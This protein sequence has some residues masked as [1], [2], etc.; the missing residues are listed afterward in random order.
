MYKVVA[1]K[2]YSVCKAT[3]WSSL[4]AAHLAELLLFCRWLKLQIPLFKV[5]GGG[6]SSCF[7]LL[8]GKG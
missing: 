7:P 1:I 5:T 3:N 2:H 4:V 6:G 8:R